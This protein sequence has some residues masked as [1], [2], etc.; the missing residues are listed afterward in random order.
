MAKTKT[1]PKKQETRRY[2]LVAGLHQDENGLHNAKDPK[3]CIVE[4]RTDLVKRFPEKFRRLDESEDLPRAPASG[5]ADADGL[6]NMTNEQLSQL[7]HDNEV[8][9]SGAESRE[10]VIE[11]IR[12]ALGT[13]ADDNS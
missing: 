10:D 1:D 7:A 11:L 2:R 9:L 4:S 8:D 13:D 5:V 3:T 12:N 6:E